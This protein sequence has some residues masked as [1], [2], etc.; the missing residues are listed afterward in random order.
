MDIK[1]TK[2]CPRC[3]ET[4]QRVEFYVRRAAN[5]GLETYCKKCKIDDSVQAAKRNTKYWATHDPYTGLSI[6][7]GE[8]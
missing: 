4:K 3:K 8:Q 6:D 2:R 5:D 7:N 1:S